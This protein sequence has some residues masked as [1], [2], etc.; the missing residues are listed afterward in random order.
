VNAFVLWQG[1][2]DRRSPAGKKLRSDA[3]EVA[4]EEGSGQSP[5]AVVGEYGRNMMIEECANIEKSC[6]HFTSTSHDVRRWERF[7]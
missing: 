6:M 3:F 5:A 4:D 1:C 2:L 7:Y